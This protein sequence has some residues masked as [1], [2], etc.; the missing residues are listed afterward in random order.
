MRRR[1][2]SAKGGLLPSVIPFNLFF[3]VLQ[4]H[5]ELTFCLP[6][7]LE[8]GGIKAGSIAVVAALEHNKPAGISR[9]KRKK[10]NEVGQG[11]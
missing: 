1:T 8:P 11:H 6:I 7:G 2:V 10:R 5:Q 4:L 3:E 9:H